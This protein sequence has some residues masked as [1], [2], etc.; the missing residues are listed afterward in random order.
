MLANNTEINGKLES[1]FFK[2]KSNPRRILAIDFGG[3]ERDLENDDEKYGETDPF[4]ED[5]FERL[6][7]G[8]SF[9]WIAKLLIVP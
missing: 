9:I 5:E 4:F 8:G 7:S 2:L 6:A 3:G 1:V